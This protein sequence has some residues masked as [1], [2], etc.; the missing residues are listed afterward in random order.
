MKSPSRAPIIR[1][2]LLAGVVFLGSTACGSSSSDGASKPTN[3]SGRPSPIQE[4]KD[5]VVL[6]V[7]IFDPTTCKYTKAEFDCT[8]NLPTIRFNYGNDSRVNLPLE[9]NPNPCAVDGGQVDVAT[10]QALL[11]YGVQYMD[12][13]TV[14]G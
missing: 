1:T 14:S 5:G 6:P 3:C 9:T 4:R 8:Q 2:L 13:G 10:A 7:Q 12:Q 11:D